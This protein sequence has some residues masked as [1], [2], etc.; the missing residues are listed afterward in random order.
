[1]LNGMSRTVF[2]LQY[3]ISLMYLLLSPSPDTVLH[4]QYYTNIHTIS[5]IG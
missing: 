4:V 5:T 2:R 3:D 1:M